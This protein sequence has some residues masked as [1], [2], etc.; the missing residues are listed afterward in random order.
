MRLTR[1]ILS[2]RMKPLPILHRSSIDS[3]GG[4][5]YSTFASD[6]EANLT[7]VRTYSHFVEIPL[8]SLGNLMSEF[9]ARY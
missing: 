6:C 5:S 7:A 3:S 1:R 2:M 8:E 4:N 9:A